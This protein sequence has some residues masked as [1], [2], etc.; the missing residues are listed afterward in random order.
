M[1]SRILVAV[2]SLPV[3]A[4][5]GWALAQQA[6]QRPVP[7]DPTAVRPVEAPPNPVLVQPG[8]PAAPAMPGRYAV[9]T[10]ASGSLVL[11][12]TVTGRTWTMRSVN[13]TGP[14]VW[15]PIRRLDSDKEVQ[16]WLQEEGMRGA[17]REKA[18]DQERRAAQEREAALRL[19]LEAIRR[20]AQAQE[21]QARR[22]LQ[23]AEQRLLELEKKKA[24]SK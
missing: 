20:Q 9:A 2:L 6:G 3:L 11:V 1:S 4:P 23:Q 18:V 15:L 8:Q 16:K 14:G 13:L 24:P 7:V 10:S 19:E 12:D 5:A 21:E 17:E 22:A